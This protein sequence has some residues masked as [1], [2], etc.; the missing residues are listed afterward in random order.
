MHASVFQALCEFYAEHR[1][2]LD[3]CKVADVGALNLNGSVKDA[4][5]HCVGFDI[6]A[7]PGVDVVI[8]PGQIPE[9]HKHQY[10]AVI[11]VSS[12]QFCPD[13]RIYRAQILDLL[14]PRGLLF[15]TLCSPECQVRH[16]TSDNQYG[17]VDAIRAEPADIAR[18]FKR[19]F[20]IQQLREVEDEHSDIVLA[21][22]LK[23]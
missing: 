21:A 13:A 5:K 10:G 17:F 15:L 22:R 14:G 23:Q 18:F 4:I 12:F 6:V 8:T 7:G 16:T 9:E 11:S 19:D 2:E 3:S 1:N 20:D